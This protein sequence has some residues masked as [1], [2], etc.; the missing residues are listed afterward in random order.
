MND[1]T[2]VIQIL[3]PSHQLYK[4]HGDGPLLDWLMKAVRDEL[5]PSNLRTGL[6]RKWHPFNMK[7]VV[8]FKTQNVHHS[9]CIEAKKES[10]VGLG[11]ISEKVA[12]TLDPLCEI[13]FSDALG[14]AAEDYFATGN[15]Y[16]EVVR[17]KE[18]EI[19]GIYHIR[20]QTAYVWVEDDK[21]HRHYE[22][23]GSETEGFVGTKHFAVFGDLDRFRATDI[24]GQGETT[25][26]VIHFRRPTSMSRWYGFPDWIAATASIELVQALTQHQF[27]FFLNRGVPEF[28]LTVT[29]S[30]AV[31]KENWDKIEAAMKAQIG[32]GKSHKSIA[33]NLVGD[34]MKVQV[35][36]LALENQAEATY[37]S[38]M[39]DTLSMHIVSAHR[40]PPVLAG[41]L[42]PGKLGANNELPNALAAFQALVMGPAQRNFSTVLA[43][44]LGNPQFNQGLG[45]SPKDFRGETGNGFRTILDEMGEGMAGLTE[46]DTM[47]RM[48]ETIPEAMAGG[49]NLE[50]GVLSQ[51]RTATPGALRRPTASKEEV[52]ERIGEMLGRMFSVALEKMMVA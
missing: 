22:I 24:G 19:R 38:E 29:G 48:R 51:R 34:D 32:L 21:M 50:A 8:D 18:G 27:D 6:G 17:S 2:R 7:A 43:N 33:W 35:D 5:P 10:S 40:V 42:V 49:R 41:I 39:M 13:S 31:S 9:A 3:R 28:I 23:A 46:M 1:D 11:F 26:E 37:F 12:E 4:E 25:S 20:A 45:L 47:A 30:R 52:E 36:K 14:D 15:G 16:L 44:T